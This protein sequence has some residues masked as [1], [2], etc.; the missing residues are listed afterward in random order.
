[1]DE[2]GLRLYFFLNMEA[3]YLFSLTMVASNYSLFSFLCLRGT[4][5]LLSQGA[6]LLLAAAI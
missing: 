6:E 1:M 4:E 2:E 3:V 5:L